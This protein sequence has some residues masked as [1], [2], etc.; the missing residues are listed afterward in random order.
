MAGYLVKYF[1]KDKGI[2][3]GM[4]R[5][6]PFFSRK[7]LS[8]VLHLPH[9]G[10]LSV[11]MEYFHWEGR[12]SHT[13]ERRGGKIAEVL[14]LEGLEEPFKEV[15]EGLFSRTGDVYYLAS[16]A[17][18]HFLCMMGIREGARK[19]LL[20]ERIRERAYDLYVNGGGA[21]PKE[22]LETV[23]LDHHLLSGG[24][25][26]GITFKAM[27]ILTTLEMDIPL[28][29]GPWEERSLIGSAK[30]SAV[31]HEQSLSI[32]V[33]LKKGPSSGWS[34]YTTVEKVEEGLFPTIGEIERRLSLLQRES[35]L[36][37]NVIYRRGIM[38]KERMGRGGKAKKD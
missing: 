1:S 9:R 34:F 7:Q 20:L 5:I 36:E 18:P 21:F 37:G 33:D 15:V 14:L 22:G 23:I 30:V 16:R 38:W 13:L 35:E 25:G 11:E 6:P 24:V 4:V 3:I 10:T 12:I 28:L 29:I 19:A 27:S 8:E 32:W 26:M 2:P 17:L 31:G